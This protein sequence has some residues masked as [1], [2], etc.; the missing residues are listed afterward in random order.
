MIPKLVIDID[1]R[2]AV[3]EVLA[4][5][6]PFI[7]GSARLIARERSL[8]E[9]LSQE[10]AI[11]LWQIDPTR[12]DASETEYVRAVLYKEM[13]LAFRREQRERGGRKRVDVGGM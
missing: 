6:E 10:A 8:A 7:S 12:F 1:T 2:D 11:K 13:L 4:E 5:L 9:D 3:V